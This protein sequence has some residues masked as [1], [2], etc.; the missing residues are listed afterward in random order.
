MT[1]VILYLL[2]WSYISPYN[3]KNNTYDI[4]GLIDAYVEKNNGNV[5]MEIIEKLRNQAK[6]LKEREESLKNQQLKDNE[7]IKK[8]KEKENNLN[9]EKTK[10][11]EKIKK[12]KKEQNDF[13][14][15]NIS[16]NQ[17]TLYFEQEL[18]KHLIE[19]EI[20]NQSNNLFY[21]LNYFIATGQ[22]IPITIEIEKMMTIQKNKECERLIFMIIIY[23]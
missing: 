15:K 12:F 9:K 13:N 7:L 21:N 4:L 10:L 17:S 11:E 8:M 2:D 18:S 20:S 3:K 23:V 6:T 16:I 1:A 5:D 14:K 19:K 22:D